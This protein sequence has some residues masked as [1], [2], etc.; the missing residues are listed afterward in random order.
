MFWMC[1]DCPITK[2][3]GLS[4][5]FSAS[6]PGTV[7]RFAL[8]T[9]ECTAGGEI[10]AAIV[11]THMMLQATDLGLGSI[12][13]MTWDPEKLRHEFNLDEHPERS[14]ADRGLQSAGDTPLQRSFAL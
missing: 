7:F 8:Q 4:Y 2:I 10:D 9:P 13:F 3:T 11:T 5:G 14:I 12:W 6:C 1:Y